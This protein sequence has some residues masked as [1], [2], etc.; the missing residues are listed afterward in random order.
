MTQRSRPCWDR[1][2]SASGTA[3]AGWRSGHSAPS[4][5]CT[6]PRSVQ[7]DHQALVAGQV[8]AP[9]ARAEVQGHQPAP[10]VAGAQVGEHVAVGLDRLV[11]AR[12]QGPGCRGAGRVGGGG[13]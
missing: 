8:Q 2:S 10:V 5:T 1:S 9:G 3:S 13:G 7:P 6:R 4:R 12:G 11:G